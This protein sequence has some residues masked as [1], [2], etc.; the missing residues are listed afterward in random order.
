MQFHI[1]SFEG[2]DP[3]ARAGGLATR[4]DGLA[5]T[6]AALGFATH[7]WFV[8]APE[9]PGHEVRGELHLHRWAQWISRHHPHGVYD[10]EHGKQS[11]YAATV[12]PHVVEW[13][14]PHLERGGRGVVLAEEWHTVDAVLHLDWLLRRAGLRDR[15]AILW[16]ANNSFGFGSIDWQRLSRAARV[17]TVSRYMKQRMW[18]LGVDPVVVPNGL[19]QDAFDQ[20]DRTACLELRRRFRDRTLVAKM[21]R[22]DPDKR[23]LE[24][25]ESVALMK[26]LGWRPL[27]LARGGAEAHG[28]AV[29]GSVRAHG[30]SCVERD[31]R[32][33]GALGLLDAL[34]DV[35]GADVVNLRSHVDPEARRPLFRGA[36]AVLANSAHEPFGLVGLEAMAAGGLACT[37][38]TG[39]DYAV[40][41]RNAIVLETS[42]PGELLGW[43]RR[44]R[45]RPAEGRAM[46][47]AGRWTA[48]LFAWPEVVERV[49]LP[50]V[51]LLMA[52]ARARR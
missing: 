7:L 3:Y 21:A 11:E 35:K 18:P 28:T 17:T 5:A 40:P 48:R 6:L 30:L 32:K 44:V 26:R 43:L 24:A 34:S 2:P 33:P 38:A 12:P 49:L 39:E 50:R 52:A 9:L 8:G 27:L 29:L 37:G 23:W 1:L 31:W 46:R 22:W 14:R 16:N 20:P 42:D 19:P 25:V 51:E 41:G 47:R 15:V 10:G 45:E 13:L 4:V 36:D